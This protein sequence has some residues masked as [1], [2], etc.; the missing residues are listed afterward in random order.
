VLARVH[1]GAIAPAL[2]SRRRSR[3]MRIPSDPVARSER[4]RGR[5]PG[6]LGAKRRAQSV[7]GLSCLS[8][9][10][11]L[12]PHRAAAQ[13]D[14]VRV[15]DEAVADGVGDRG[16][17]N[18]L[19]PSFGRKLR[20]QNRRRLV[21]AILEH[22]E[23]VASFDVGHRS[24]KKVVEYEDV[25]LREA[26]ERAGVRAVGAGDR[27]LLQEP[28]RTDA[29]RTESLTACGLS[30]CG[31]EEALAGPGRAYDDD[32]LLGAHP[33]ARCQGPQE[34]L[35]DPARRFARDL[36]DRNAARHAGVFE[37][38]VQPLVLPLGPFSIDKQALVLG[39]IRRQT[40]R[41]TS[42]R[43][44]TLDTTMDGG[45]RRAELKDFLRAHRAAIAPEVAGFPRAA[46]RMT[47]GLRREELASLAGVSLTW[48]T[49]LEQGRRGLGSDDAEVGR[50]LSRGSLR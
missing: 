4:T 27:E 13:R 20:G 12:L 50:N 9:D 6:S 18:R 39:V 5:S 31:P 36:L 29:E 24:E 34:R 48:Y 2:A 10:G 37:Q 38:P 49:W 44:A 8:G 45:A 47:R 28:R 26:G 40:T 35:V 25:D 21:V 43:S 22:L 1:V 46:R 32:V 11:L 33:L 14:Q 15:M 7:L 42:A 41:A 3:C 17:S 19:M 16:L 23:Q 30:E